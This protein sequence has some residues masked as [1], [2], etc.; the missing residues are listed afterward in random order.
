M[1]TKAPLRKC[2]PRDDFC[3]KGARGAGELFYLGESCCLICVSLY[4][5]IFVLF[6]S[7]AW[8]SKQLNDPF[9]FIFWKT[10]EHSYSL[11][12]LFRC[13]F[14]LS[15][16]PTFLS[17]IWSHSHMT[18]FFIDF[19]LIVFFHFVRSLQET[20][21]STTNKMRF[22]KHFLGSRNFHIVFIQQQSFINNINNINT[23]LRFLSC[24]KQRW[25]GN[26][27]FW[28]RISATWSRSHCAS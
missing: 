1:E 27:S 11:F 21:S 13:S 3:T 28:E 4:L 19:A 24:R 23:S 25:S 14:L 9:K 17:I 20:K 2:V 12:Y 6:D 18:F 22:Q 16:F 7:C 10:P 15:F 26:H 8:F 5:C